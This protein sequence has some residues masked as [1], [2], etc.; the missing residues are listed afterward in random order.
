MACNS[1]DEW[2]VFRTSYHQ[3]ISPLPC[4]AVHL[5]E[6]P[7]GDVVAEVKWETYVNYHTTISLTSQ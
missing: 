5:I 7:C 4:S 2:E 1:S 3:L 6:L